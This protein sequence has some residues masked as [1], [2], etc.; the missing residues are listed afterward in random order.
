M[1]GVSRSNLEQELMRSTAIRFY[2]FAVTRAHTDI[3]TV[4]TGLAFTLGAGNELVC[5]AIEHLFQPLIG[6]DINDLISEWGKV[7]ASLADHPQLRWVGPHK[8]VVHLTLASI[9]NAVFDLW[10]KDRGVPL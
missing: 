3:G 10:A 5:Q 4:G 2:F 8:G 9:T 1:N 6:R 7:S